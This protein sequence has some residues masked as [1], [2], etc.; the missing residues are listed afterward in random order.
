[1]VTLLMEVSKSEEPLS[2]E[3]IFKIKNGIEVKKK[4]SF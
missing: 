4:L 1:M 2:T 3:R